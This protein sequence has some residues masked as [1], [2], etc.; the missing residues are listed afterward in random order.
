MGTLKKQGNT[1]AISLKNL[2]VDKPYRDSPEKPIPQIA[3]LF[4]RSHTVAQVKPKGLEAVIEK[5]RDSLDL[6]IKAVKE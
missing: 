6:D 5:N 3:S 2:E 4:N 1:G